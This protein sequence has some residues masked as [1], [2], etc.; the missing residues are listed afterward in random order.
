MDLLLIL[1]LIPVAILLVWFTFKAF[2]S[3]TNLPEKATSQICLIKLKDSQLI[4]G[5]ELMQLLTDQG[6]DFNKQQGVF[7]LND[8]EQIVL[9][10]MNLK[11]PGKFQEPF[12]EIGIPGLMLVTDLSVIYDDMKKH[13]DAMYEFGLALQKEFGGHLIDQNNIPV[14]SD[15]AQ[16]LHDDVMHNKKQHDWLKE[17][18]S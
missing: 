17:C 12:E 10:C 14:G 15:W 13:L 8:G 1:I 5:Y 11:K 4:N 16:H 2:F 6:F 7:D 18:T 9:R 3:K